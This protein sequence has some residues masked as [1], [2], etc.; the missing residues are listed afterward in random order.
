MSIL[1]WQPGS[2]E[3]L[4]AMESYGLAL[5]AGSDTDQVCVIDELGY[6]YL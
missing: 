4:W 6:L 2:V 1:E 3:I 5:N